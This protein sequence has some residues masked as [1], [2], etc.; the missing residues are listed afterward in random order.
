MENI[1]D[2]V[3]I[4]GGPAGYTCALY[5]ARAGF[6]VVVFEKFYAGGQM[7]ITEMVENYPGFELGIDGF[8]LAEKMKAQAERFGVKT[9]LEEVSELS[10]DGKTKKIIANGKEYLSKTVV[11]ATGANPKELGVKNEDK[12]KGRGVH[13]CASCDGMFYKNKTVAVVGGGDTAVGDAMLLSRVANKVYLI[14]RR[15]SLK[16]TKIYHDALF[17]LENVSV[18]YDSVV[19]EISGENSF[20]GLVIE[21]VKTKEKSQILCDGVF[22]SIGRKPVTK[23]IENIVNLDENGYVIAGEDTK[24]NIEGIYAIGDVRTKPLRQVVTAVGDGANAVYF[25]EN[26]ILKSY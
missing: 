26:Y 24:T 7:A 22:V 11:I 21:N 14:H 1:L 20:E 16:A 3:I 9:L 13:Y 6:N 2:I 18:I 4:G 15:D 23:L 12:F 17:K 10:L 5:G 19:A 25:I 8:E